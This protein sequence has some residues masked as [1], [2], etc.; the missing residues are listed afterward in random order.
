MASGADDAP[1]N[2]D[3]G[4]LWLPPHDNGTGAVE[5]NDLNG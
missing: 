2:A 3:E 5:E 4:V 1:K